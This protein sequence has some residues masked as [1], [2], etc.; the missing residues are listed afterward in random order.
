M[1]QHGADTVIGDDV[2]LLIMDCFETLV[3]LEGGQYRL[4]NGVDAFLLHF[5]TRLSIPLA[6]HSDAERGLLS[7]V[8]ESVGLQRY[9]AALYDGD[10]AGI[11]LDNG[12]LLKDLAQPLADFKVS[13]D[14]AVFIGDSRLDAQSAERFDVPFIRVPRSEDRQF[15][16]TRLIGG[17]SRYKSGEFTQTMLR[18]YLGDQHERDA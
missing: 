9:A 18:H 10:Q 15:S 3:T 12:L 5:V 16:F 11:P 8:I 2:R 6:I 17:S 1:G 4:R 13:A 7:S 14:D